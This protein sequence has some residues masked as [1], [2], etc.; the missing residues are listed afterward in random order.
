M[1]RRNWAEVAVGAVV[2]AVAGGFLGFAVSSSGRTT[3][4]GY[5]LYA[6]FEHIDGLGVGSEVRL[7]GVK[8]GTITSARIDPQTYQAVVGFSVDNAI[9]LPKDTSGMITSDGLLGSKYLSLGPGG[10]TA[11]LKPGDTLTI[12]QGSISIE[13]L[14]GK[15][16]FSASNLADNQRKHEAPASGPGSGTITGGGTAGSGT[17]GGGST[18]GGTG[19]GGTGSGGGAPH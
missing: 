2:I 13:E 19:T 6:D 11:D 3:V 12:T 7:A 1:A 14:L 17:M 10:D 4:G 16:I 9:K 18:S 8:I 5:T 15:F